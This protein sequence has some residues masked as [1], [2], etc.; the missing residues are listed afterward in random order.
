ME[1]IAGQHVLVEQVN[2]NDN[3][4]YHLM[5]AILSLLTRKCCDL[6]RVMWT[7]STHTFYHRFVHVQPLIAGEHGN[8]RIFH[9]SV[10][11]LPSLKNILVVHNS[12]VLISNS[13]SGEHLALEPMWSK[14]YLTCMNYENKYF[15][16]MCFSL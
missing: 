8:S 2:V 3:I 16:F 1:M 6:R 13:Q 14:H 11:L 15:D 5:R 7:L 4:R 12:R 10:Y 9:I